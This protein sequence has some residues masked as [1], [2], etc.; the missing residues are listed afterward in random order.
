MGNGALKDQVM[1]QA[2]LEEYL[3]KEKQGLVENIVNQ[4]AKDTQKLD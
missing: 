3:A 2:L 4:Y 1:A